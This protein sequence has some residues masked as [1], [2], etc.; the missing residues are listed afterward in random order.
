MR[1]EEST[2]EIDVDLLDDQDMKY[3]TILRNRI[4]MLISG[5]AFTLHQSVARE[6]GLES[7]RRLAKRCNP[8]APMRGLQL[9]LEWWA[10][11][12]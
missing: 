12:K 1:A 11:A 4:T 5:P 9:M 6:S 8:A 2:E 3:A 7:R 10:R